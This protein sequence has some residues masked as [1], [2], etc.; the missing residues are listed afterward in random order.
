[1]R[2]DQLVEPQVVHAQEILELDRSFDMPYTASSTAPLHVLINPFAWLLW[3]IDFLLWVLLNPL[4]GLGPIKMLLSLVQRPGLVRGEDG[5][6]PQRADPGPGPIRAGLPGLP[7]HHDRARDDAGSRSRNPA[8][9]RGARPPVPARGRKRG[10]P[11]CR[12]A[13]RIVRRPSASIPAPPKS[14]PRRARPPRSDS[15]LS[16]VR[17]R[18]CLLSPVHSPSRSQTLQTRNLFG[19]RAS[20]SAS[21]RPRRAPLREV[22]SRR[23]GGRTATCR[24]ARPRLGAGARRARL[25]AAAAGVD[26]E[27]LDG[28]HTIL[29]WEDTCAD[30]LTALIGAGGQSIAVATSYATLGISAVARRSTTRRAP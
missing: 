18:P 4:P 10:E 15:T 5:P 26:Y 17:A 1:M 29:L 12:L 2:T 20:A 8:R 19:T 7:R 21:T 22:R 11:A 3:A 28:P 6:A 23:R 27:N 16:R 30:W 14:P 25:Q 13:A 24:R 9:V